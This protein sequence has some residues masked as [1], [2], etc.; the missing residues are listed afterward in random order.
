MMLDPQKKY[1]IGLTFEILLDLV[2]KK[3]GANV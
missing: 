3:G 2:G 1:M